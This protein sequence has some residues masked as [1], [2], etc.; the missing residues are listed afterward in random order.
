MATAKFELMPDEAVIDTW[1]LLYT[2]PGGGKY[3]GKCTI[4]NKRIFYDA[5]LDYSA[6]GIAS[7][8]FVIESGSKG[9]LQIPKSSIKDTAVKKSFLNKSVS[10]T[11]DDG[12]V[13]TFSYGA[14]NIDKVVDAM[15]VR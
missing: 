9:Y 10:L 15:N 8:F 13:H 6:G 2:P 5:L 4:T 3:N 1:T 11:L 14:M 12:Q 7:S